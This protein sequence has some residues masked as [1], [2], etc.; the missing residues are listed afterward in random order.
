[1]LPWSG[2]INA[3]RSFSVTLF[4]VPLLP[5]MQRAFPAG[6]ENDTFRST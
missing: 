3:M 4:P 5:K 6:T 2:L 1:M